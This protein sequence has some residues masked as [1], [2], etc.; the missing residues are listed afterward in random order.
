MA[1]F[2][3]NSAVR[4]RDIDNLLAK[5]SKNVFRSSKTVVKTHIF[6]RGVNSGVNVNTNS[7]RKKKS[8]GQYKLS[9][10]PVV[11]PQLRLQS[12]KR[13]Y[14]SNV[15]CNVAQDNVGNSVQG[16]NIDEW[17]HTQSENIPG[18]VMGLNPINHKSKVSGSNLVNHNC[19]SSVLDDS[20]GG[21][22][23]LPWQHNQLKNSGMVMGL[24]PINHYD[25]VSGS[26]LV[27]CGSSVSDDIAGG[28]VPLY[29]VNSVGVEEKFANSIIHSKQFNESSIPLG[30]DS[31]IFKKW[32]VQSDFQFGFIPLGDQLMP[33][34]SFHNSMPN[35][36]LIDAHY[37]IR[38][39]GKPNFW[40]ARIPVTSQLNV[41]KWEELLQGYW[42][43]QLLQLLRF[44]FPLDF[45]RSCPLQ[46]EQGNHT[47]AIQFP[48]DVDAYIEEECGYGALLG[49]FKENPIEHCHTSPFMTR[50]KPNS[51]RRRVIIDLSWPIGASVNA[52]IDKDT[53][54]NSPFALT[55]PSVDDIMSQLRRLGRG[56]LLYKIDVSRAFRHVRI[57]P[58]DFDLLGLHWQEP[59]FSTPQ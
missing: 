56:A 47:S 30:V 20:A 42:D 7:V 59:G 25:K 44:G 3:Y 24:N 28:G 29:D 46:Y 31:P 10:S 39:R 18:M 38:H 13:E 17:Q 48:L 23:L 5:K 4:P 32:R 21:G 52:G 26:N 33:T 35:G 53:Y 9:S 45:N 15:Q 27:H 22:R 51:D 40:G 19:G 8:N 57:D 14:R 50:N 37:V 16:S 58:G 54:L 43:Q 34:Q 2:F 6:G 12:P 36:S 49:P 41:D 11:Q 1:R 55:F